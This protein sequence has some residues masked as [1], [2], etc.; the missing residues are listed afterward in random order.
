[1][2][3]KSSGKARQTFGRLIGAVVKQVCTLDLLTLIKT[4]A[5]KQAGLML[6]IGIIFVCSPA[7][8]LKM[9]GRLLF[10]WLLGYSAWQLQAM[11]H[12]AKKKKAVDYG[13]LIFFGI[14][15][16][17]EVFCMLKGSIA[18]FSANIALAALFGWRCVS[19]IKATAQRWTQPAQHWFLS[20]A[21]AILAGMLGIVAFSAGSSAL[22]EFIM[23]AGT[24]LILYAAAVF[25]RDLIEHQRKLKQEQRL[26]GQSPLEND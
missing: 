11:L 2:I 26:Q 8:A 9:L 16:A 24:Y 12:S 7:W 22:V 6:V 3:G 5:V 23:P 13:K 1:M 18:I 19:A 17:V 15:C 10:L 4:R 14:V 20:L 25:T 21:D